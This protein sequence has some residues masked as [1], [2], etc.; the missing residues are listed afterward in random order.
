MKKLIS[1][2]TLTL[3]AAKLLIGFAIHKANELGVSGAIVT[4]DRPAMRTLDSVIRQNLRRV[5]HQVFFNYHTK[6]MYNEINYNLKEMHYNIVSL[7]VD[8]H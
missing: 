6:T 2:H 8:L 1:K 5:I 3:E 7:F 4:T